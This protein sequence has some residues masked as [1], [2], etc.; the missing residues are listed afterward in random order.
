M[1]V[2]R[3]SYTEQL[4]LHMIIKIIKVTFVILLILVIFGLYNSIY[5]D[6]PRND[7]VSKHAK[8]NSE[9]IELDDGSLIH[10]RDEGNKDG[11]IL[12][13]VHGF[14]GSLFN[15]E[16]MTPF[17]KDQFRILS[18]DLPAH[19]LTGSVKSNLYSYD[20]FYR[21]I[22]EVLEKQ[23]IRKFYLIG[24]SMGGMI[25]WR[26]SLERSE[27]IKGLIIIGSP[28]IGSEKA[29][30]EFQSVNAPPAAFELLESRIFREMLAYITPRFLVKEGVSQ[31]VYDQ[32]LVTEELVDQF[33]EII[34]QEGSREAM[35]ELLINFEDNFI[36]DPTL[37]KNID[38]PTL[39]LHGEEDNL[40]DLRFVNHFVEKIPDVKLVTYPEVGHMP[41]MEIP[42]KLAND[43]EAFIKKN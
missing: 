40:V 9:F 23:D 37:L 20:G 30:N 8:G 25:A 17:L 36:S 32:N 42:E 21:V 18:L 14:N 10:I 13:M 11:K 43:I 27:Q 39:I 1:R 15:F 19:G 7:V 35:G 38:M 33:H 16:T 12:V 29:Y 6:I 5:F 2:K 31:T 22:S 28:F 4:L 3:G 24:H 26:Y 41:T 34:L